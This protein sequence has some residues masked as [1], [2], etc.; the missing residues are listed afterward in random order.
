MPLL[1]AV[2]QS[3]A[4]RLRPVLLTTLTTVVALMPMALGLHGGSASFGPFAASIT[5]G[6]IFAMVGTLFIVP[7]AYTQLIH[8]QAWLGA[9]VGAWRA[10]VGAAALH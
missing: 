2:R 4:Q 10:A 5:F 9:R 7:L 1:E 3:G 8:V 6:L